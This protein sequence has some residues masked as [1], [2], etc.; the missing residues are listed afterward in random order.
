MFTDRKVGLPPSSKVKSSSSYCWGDSLLL[1]LERTV[2]QMLHSA[3]G[4]ISSIARNNQEAKS[5]YKNSVLCPQISPYDDEE[6]TG[7]TEA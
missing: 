7:E 1:Q 4:N 3:T 5:E 6:H 2:T